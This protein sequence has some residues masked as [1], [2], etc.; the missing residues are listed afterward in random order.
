MYKVLNSTEDQLNIKSKWN[1]IFSVEIDNNTWKIVFKACFKI[2]SDNNLIWVQ[3]RIIHRI[4][5]T[6][7]L[8]YAMNMKDGPNCRLCSNNEETMLHLFVEC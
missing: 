7:K 5:G 1:N 4:L 6:Q 3:Y 8:R 2:L